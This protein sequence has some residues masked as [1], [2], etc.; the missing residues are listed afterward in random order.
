VAALL[1]SAALQ[2]ASI[3]A[4]QTFY[5]SLVTL[6]NI[7][8]DEAY[9]HEAASM[10]QPQSPDNVAGAPT[11][12][13]LS[14]DAS[15]V[16]A[17]MAISG[18]D[19]LT[20]VTERIPKHASVELAGYRQAAK[21]NAVY[22]FKDLPVD[23]RQIRAIGVE[24]HL[25]AVAGRDFARGIQSVQPGGGRSS[26]IRTRIDGRPNPE[27]LLFMGTVDT[28]HWRHTSAVSE[29]TIDGR[30]LR[31]ILL[32]SPIRPGMLAKL[33]LS[34]SIDK[35]V[36][37][38]IGFHPFGSKF[39]V[40]VIREEWP[41]N[42]PLAPGVQGNVTRVHL[43]AAGDPSVKMSAPGSPDN[44]NMWDMITR[45]CFLCGAVPYFVGSTL[46]IRRARNIFDT[47][48]GKVP[49]GID[50]SKG[51]PF[52]S[53]RSWNGQPLKVRRMV[54]G[55]NV[56]NLEFERKIGGV[57][58]PA[59]ELVCVNTS[60]PTRGINPQTGRPNK[61]LLAYY[62]P[63]ADPA[64]RGPPLTGKAKYRAST[65]VAPNGQ[66]AMTDLLRFSVPG[67]ASLAQLQ[68]MARDTWEEI[69]RQEISGRISTKDLTSLGG[70]NNDPDL[71]RL[72]PGDPLQILVRSDASNSLSPVNSELIRQERFQQAALA[73]SF[74]ARTG[75]SNP[76][77]GGA[78][79]RT[80]K[81]S[82]V[83]ELL[84]IFRVSNVKF[85]W[86]ADDGIAI[87]ADFQNYV[88]VVL[89]DGAQDPNSTP[90]S[91]KPPA[92]GPVSSPATTNQPGSGGGG[93]GP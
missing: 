62:P 42:T 91:A 82:A 17:F 53:H 51:D 39:D 69:A 88:E 6:L 32:D 2:A 10:S 67:I 33:V 57:T 25:G 86:G 15:T 81:G 37:Q 9:Q 66:G 48:L 78:V 27:T 8:L 1:N 54:Y 26:V 85:S 12:Q 29:V 79:A 30:D 59:V 77:A 36:R 22:D 50:P 47:L 58:R 52:T 43:G 35:V 61:L 23:P 46:W 70:G 80:K 28:L 11:T 87:D 89:S 5:P 55:S 65:K 76:K 49:T 21:F 74:D 31:G 71:L 63:E 83:P 60:S 92:P 64:Y 72:R 7:R 14:A 19:Y 40:R 4:D 41:N 75:Q 44:L 38:I 24:V 84:N 68:E 45:Y 90:Q 73:K 34:N 3:R 56:L 93:V 16:P 18:A 20:V 13:A